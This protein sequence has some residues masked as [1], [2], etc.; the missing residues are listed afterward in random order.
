ML[1]YFARLS[2][3][4]RCTAR[5]QTC[6]CPNLKHTPH[7]LA[8]ERSPVNNACLPVHCCLQKALPCLH[9]LTFIHIDSTLRQLPVLVCLLEISFHVPL[10]FPQTICPSFKTQK[11]HLLRWV[12]RA[13]FNLGC[14]PHLTLLHLI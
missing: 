13:E 10:S 3:L 11:T 5:T 14:L 8:L 6:L 1:S 12:L 9:F 2:Q 4:G 7:L